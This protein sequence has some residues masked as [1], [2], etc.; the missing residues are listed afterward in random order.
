MMLAAYN[1]GASRVEEW[2]KNA[3]APQL[4]EESFISKIGIASTNSYVSSILKRYRQK[5]ED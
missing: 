5:S 3:N 1:A 4:A 2:T